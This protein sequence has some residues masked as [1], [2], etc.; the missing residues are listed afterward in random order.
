MC[1]GRDGDEPALATTV[2]TLRREVI[3]RAPE[4][5]RFLAHLARAATLNEPPLTFFRGFVLAKEGEHA[6]TL[7]IK[8]GGVG[9]VVELARVEAL[10]AGSPAL[11]TVARLTAAVSAGLI[12][13]ER[14]ADLKDAFEFISYVR[15][16]HQ[17]QQSRAGRPVDNRVN[18]SQ[19]SSFDKRA[20][21]E[22]FGIV[23][24]A[25]SSLVSMFPAGLG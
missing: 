5:R 8:R 21:R 14:G 13:E 10:A 24:G 25:Q 16:R 12:G 4:S 9:A 15:I 20:L 2:A 19:L 23:R 1:R 18:P 6:A 11:N 17:A 22:A 3:A 7:D